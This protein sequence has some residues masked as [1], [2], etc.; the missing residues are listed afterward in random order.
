M[1]VNSNNSGNKCE[2]QFPAAS[3]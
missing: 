3:Q 2:I 1:I